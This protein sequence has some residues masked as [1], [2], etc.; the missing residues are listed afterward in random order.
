MFCSKCGA[1]LSQGVAFCSNCGNPTVTPA[2]SVY[3]PAPDYSAGPTQGQ[4]QQ[5]S[6]AQAP[7]AS[8]LSVAAFVVSLFLPFIGLFM[9]Y[10]ARNEIRNSNGT[11]GG[12]GLASAAIAI[13]WIFTIIGIILIGVFAA[14]YASLS[15][16]YYY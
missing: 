4:F 7:S 10:A 2:A 13:G 11:K 3:T 14:Y 1:Q 9:G 5:Q 12:N 8:G 16:D 6:Y 15:A